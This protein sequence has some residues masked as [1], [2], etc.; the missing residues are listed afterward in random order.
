MPTLED[1]DEVLDKMDEFEDK[2]DM[3]TGEVIY[4]YSKGISD[5]VTVHKKDFD[6]WV[7]L[8][9]KFKEMNMEVH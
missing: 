2:Y 5:L 9:F 4:Y 6:E 1:F 3:P 8:Y 7:N